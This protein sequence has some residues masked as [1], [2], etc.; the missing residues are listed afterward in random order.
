MK[1][2]LR[3]I[4]LLF[5]MGILN[6]CTVTNI[7]L[8]RHGEKQDS[9]ASSG[10]TPQGEQRAIALR[11][12]LINEN[13]DSIYST[14]YK[15]TQLTAKPLADALKKDIISYKPDK[16][17]SMKLKKMKGKNVVVVG[18]SNTI[19]DIIKYITTKSIE[20][21]ENEFDKL[22]IIRIR[23]FLNLNI[24]LET[25]TYGEPSPKE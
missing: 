12:V 7:Y 14:D 21:R 2:I 16:A 1:P 18:H 10:L 11:D 6:S 5:C 8:V 20:I 23:R 4:L 22:F 17:F 13:I 9:S 24:S 25:K 19:P 15:R 3:S